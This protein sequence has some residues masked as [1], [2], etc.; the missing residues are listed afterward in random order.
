MASSSTPKH[1]IVPIFPGFQLLDLA[2]PLDILNLLSYSQPGLSFKFIAESLDPVPVK[3]IVPQSAQ[4]T[5]DLQEAFPQLGDKVNTA[6][7]QYL[8]PDTTYADYL[9]A[10]N[11]PG[12][13]KPVL[14]V[15]LIPGGVGTRLTRL[16]PD[17]SKSSNIQALV[18]F[19]PKVIP[20][21]STAILTVCTGSYALAFTGL[22][23]GRRATTNMSRFD[24]VA[25]RH[26]G[27]SWQHGARWVRSLPSEA[28]GSTPIE[29][30]TS[31]GISAGMDGTLAFIAQF[32]GGL[33]VA[34]DLAK[35]LEYDWREIAEGDKDPLY[36]KYYEV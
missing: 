23:D 25:G 31:A 27:V 14:D 24:D 8:Q 20:H 7:N 6:F 34:R 30:W 17:G 29:I 2:G 33:D 35:E 26:P 12:A 10:L 13:D 16:H 11:S 28:S 9:E 4:W 18:D 36:E 1:F 22:L 19:I 5:F 21:V 3:P 15:M 32:Y